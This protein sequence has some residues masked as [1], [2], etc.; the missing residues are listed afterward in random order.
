MA[1]GSHPYFLPPWH[2]GT[3]ILST[4]SPSHSRNPK[5]CSYC[6]GLVLEDCTFD[7]DADLAFEDSDVNAT[8]LS[9]VTSVKN[10]RTGSIRARSI[11]ELII[12]ANILPPADCRIV[13]ES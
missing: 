6:K 7:A 2:K 1:Q 5:G 10:P 11:G 13:T 3:T 4:H 9:H 12:D 8:I